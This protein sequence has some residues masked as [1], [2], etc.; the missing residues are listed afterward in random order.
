[1]G[2]ESA[3]HQERVHLRRERRDR[4]LDGPGEDPAILAG[5]A[6]AVMKSAPETAVCWLRAALSA[7]PPERRGDAGHISL[8]D[9]LSRALALAGRLEESRALLREIT[10]HAFRMP[11]AVRTSAVVRHA[12]IECA[13]GNHGAARTLLGAEL[14]RLDGTPSGP[15]AA[16][17]VGHG[18]ASVLDGRDVELPRLETALRLARENGDAITEA[19]VLALLGLRDALAGRAE[20]ARDSLTESAMIMDRPPETEPAAL[21]EC[22]GVLGWGETLAGRFTEA[23]RHLRLGLSVAGRGEFSYAEPVLLVALSHLHLQVGTVTE[24]GR[25]AAEARRLL[26]RT[27]RGPIADLTRAL[28][29]QCQ[30]LTGERTSARGAGQAERAVAPSRAGALYLSV[31]GLAPL[32][33]AVRLSGDPGPCLALLLDAGGGAGLPA[34]PASLR[35]LWYELLACAA[36]DA[37]DPRAS[38]WAER[39]RNAPGAVFQDAHAVAARAH[40]LRACGD[41]PAA[42][43]LYRRAADLFRHSG[44]GNRQAWAL[45]SAAS[46]AATAGR[47]EETDMLIMLTQDVARQS[48]AAGIGRRAGELRLT[49]PVSSRSW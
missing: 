9:V 23:E 41:H 39:A 25:L 3:V 12:R 48:G 49:T 35:P 15:A 38:D 13:L 21:A 27:A 6:E 30:A 5:A 29:S 22:L 44:F 46:C 1:M 16:L 10:G 43:G 17:V 33:A 26:G 2:N 31:G 40:A 11:D 24:A 42:V 14:T 47:V 36:A 45:L 8:L 20:T 19:G 32:E 28:W 4:S 34:V 18:I 7:F 37:G